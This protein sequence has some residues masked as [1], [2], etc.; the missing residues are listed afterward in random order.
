MSEMVRIFVMPVEGGWS[1]DCAMIAMPLM[2]LS[3][4]QAE[5]KARALGVFLSR[6]GSDAMVFIHD[7]QK[8]LIG[9]AH[10]FAPDEEM[11]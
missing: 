1:V 2:F 11:A 9:T 3:G 4:A 5:K 8:A 7:R 6:L 10:Y